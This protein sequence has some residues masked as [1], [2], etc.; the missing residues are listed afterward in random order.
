MIN[1]GHAVI[2]RVQSVAIVGVVHKKRSPNAWCIP[3]PPR[4]ALHQLSEAQF[5][6][7]MLIMMTAHLLYSFVAEA[8]PSI[9]K[10]FPAKPVWYS[11]FQ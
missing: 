11:L 10:R 8:H 2:L 7:K 6:L 4:M 9:T 5:K 1:Q 3:S